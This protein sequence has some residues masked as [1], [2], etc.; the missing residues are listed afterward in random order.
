MLGQASQAHAQVMG[1][2]LERGSVQLGYAYKWFHRDME[3]SYPSE[4]R[5][6]VGTFTVRY[7]GFQWLTLS[8]EGR[9][10]NVEHD[11][12]AGL[13]FR[14]YAVG[15]GLEVRLYERGPWEVAGAFHYTEVWDH[16]DSPNHFHKRTR[17]VTTALLVGRSFDYRGQ[18]VAL[19]AGPAYVDD[20]AETYPWDSNEP[21]PNEAS[22]DFGITAGAEVL[23]FR[24]LAGV[25]WFVYAADYIQPRIGLACQ[26]GGAK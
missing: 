26:F 4:M 25:A 1:L 17:D 6:E 14:R 10:S 13:E 8:I 11:E 16:D 7:G 23:L 18:D 5:W 24:H 12:F 9:V 3:P 20:M 2:P 15:A 22:N 19:W 21:I